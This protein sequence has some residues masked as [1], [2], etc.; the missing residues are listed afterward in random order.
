MLTFDDGYADLIE[1]ALPKL[2][3]HGFPATVFVTTGWCV[4]RDGLRAGTPP[5]RMLSWAQLAELSTP[6]A[7]RWPHTLTVIRSST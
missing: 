1:E 6:P 5:G 2:I 3:E 7:S 4:T